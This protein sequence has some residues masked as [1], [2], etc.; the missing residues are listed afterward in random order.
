MPRSQHQLLIGDVRADFIA[1]L[2]E[3]AAQV[4]AA[5]QADVAEQPGAAIQGARL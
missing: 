2:L 5:V 1:V 4:V 3:F